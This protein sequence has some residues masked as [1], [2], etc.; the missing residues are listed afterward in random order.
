[1]VDSEKLS[2]CCS[3][4]G[5]YLLLGEEGGDGWKVEKT[6]AKKFTR[7]EGGGVG[8]KEGTEGW[9]SGRRGRS[10]RAETWQDKYREK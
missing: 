7:K 3:D 1:M 10:E 5:R 2:L 8:G 9:Q 6:S 4:V